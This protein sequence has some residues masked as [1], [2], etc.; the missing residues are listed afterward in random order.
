VRRG[1]YRPREADDI[2]N[3]AF[4]AGTTNQSISAKYPATYIPAIVAKNED[5]CFIAQAIPT[6]PEL[7]VLDAY[8]DFLA[9]RRRLVAG[10]L[11]EF[12][13]QVPRRGEEDQVPRAD[14]S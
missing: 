11:N 9:A 4:I 8:P 1:H 10:R 7:L 13:G 12:L 6:A 2:A 5:E 14:R 3:L